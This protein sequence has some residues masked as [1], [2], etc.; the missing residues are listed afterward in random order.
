MKWFSQINLRIFWMKPKKLQ[1][2]AFFKIKNYWVIKKMIWFL[3]PVLRGWVI[4]IVYILT[5]L[6]NFQRCVIAR[7]HLLINH[8]RF[9]EAVGA[10]LMII[11]NQ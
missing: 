11:H 3:H 10:S 8:H 4:K 9:V 2:L 7:S 6:I 1:S 5:S